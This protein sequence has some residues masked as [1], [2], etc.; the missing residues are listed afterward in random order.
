MVNIDKII[1][2]SFNKVLEN[3]VFLNEDSLSDVKKILKSYRK[4]TLDELRNKKKK[5]KAKHANRKGKKKVRK[6]AKGAKE[7]Y[8]FDEYESKNKKVSQADAES[9][10]H[11]I[12]T[13]NTDIAAVARS[14]FPKHTEEGAQSQLRKVLNGERPMTKKVATKLEKMISRGQVAVK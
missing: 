12:D 5:E 4:K 10:R 13:D 1:D 3:R 14:V 6:M 8:D 2:E 11:T 7:Y 9:I